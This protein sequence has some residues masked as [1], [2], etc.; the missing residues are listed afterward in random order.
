MS[1]SAPSA[2][3]SAPS[4]SQ[5]APS[6]SQSAPSASQSAPSASQSVPSVSQSEPSV[7]QSVPPAFLSASPVF[8][9]ASPVSLSAPSVAAPALPV[10]VFEQARHCVAESDGHTN[11]TSTDL[12]ETNQLSILEDKDFW[13][14]LMSDNDQEIL[15][16]S[17]E[18]SDS[19]SISGLST[20]RFL[21]DDFYQDFHFVSRF[22]ELVEPVDAGTMTSDYSSEGEL[23]VENVLLE[24]NNR[25]ESELSEVPMEILSDRLS[26]GYITC[27]NFTRVEPS[28]RTIFR[29]RIYLPP[30]EDDDDDDDY[31]RRPG[32]MNRTHWCSGESFRG[33]YY[34]PPDQLR[35]EQHVY[36]EDMEVLY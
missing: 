18:D 32:L 20:F 33:D 29:R 30:L 11:L 23:P 13:D 1:Q 15:E 4:V 36:A 31:I 14:D 10:S 2:S 24:E 35:L 19:E 28:Q 7:S 8:L 21:Q 27:Q 16:K 22:S 5:S 26:V 34:K 9:S 17:E 25:Q 12:E 3:Q 6:A